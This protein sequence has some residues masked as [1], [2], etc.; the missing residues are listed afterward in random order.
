MGQ[1]QRCPLISTHMKTCVRLLLF[2]H[3]IAICCIVACLTSQVR[4][5]R[6]M[7]FLEQRHD[8]K[9]RFVTD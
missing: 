5:K 6:Y 4:C 8:V 7:H 9:D 1:K 3:A 2:I